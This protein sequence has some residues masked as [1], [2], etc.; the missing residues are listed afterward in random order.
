MLFKATVLRWHHSI[1][2]KELTKRF[3]EELPTFLWRHMN[4][5]ENEASKRSSFPWER[6][7]WANVKQ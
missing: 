4:H 1:N 7:Y 2:D 6:I 5:I 3:Q